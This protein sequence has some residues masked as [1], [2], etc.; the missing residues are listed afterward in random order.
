MTRVRRV[1]WNWEQNWAP[2]VGAPAAQAG[3]ELRAALE[4]VPAYL[5]VQAVEEAPAAQAGEELRAAV[6]GVPAYL[7]VQAVEELRSAVEGVPAY[8][9]VWAPPAANYTH[10]K[11]RSHHYL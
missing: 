3:E 1:E 8:L 2:E 7:E 10:G 11:G 9:E 5:E 6:E 4:G